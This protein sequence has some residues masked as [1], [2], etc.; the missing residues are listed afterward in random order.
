MTLKLTPAYESVCTLSQFVKALTVQSS[1]KDI[2]ERTIKDF[3]ATENYMTV[4]S[5]RRALHLGLTALHL[6][7]G[8]VIFPA[9]TPDIVP[10]TLQAHGL[11]P[12][13]ADVYA[14]DYTID[15]ES[16]KERISTHTKAVVPVHTFG[17]P[18][19]MHALTD[20]CKDHNIYLIENAAPSFG[21]QYKSIPVGRYGDFGIFSFRLGK[22][23]V[24]GAGGGLTGSDEVFDQIHTTPSQAGNSLAFGGWALSWAVLSNPFLY[25]ILGHTLKNRVVRHQYD[26]FKKDLHDTKDIP[27]L[28]YAVGIQKFES[29]KRKRRIALEYID[30]LKKV[31]GVH[32]PVEKK[33]RYSVYSMFSVRVESQLKRDEIAQKMIHAHIEPGIPA[34]GYP[35][36]EDLYPSRFDIPIS[37][38]LSRTSIALPVN[39]R[40]PEDTLIDI[41]T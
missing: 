27:A 34:H 35:V 7:K 36:S 10:L 25:Y 9:F 15:I 1:A 40:I 16:V 24:M 33:D 32:V 18:S 4:S 20:I 37:D 17:Y 8:H 6:T 30:I 5:G 2:F 41:F 13:P 14:D 21:A 3:L 19:D 38:M 26:T 31:D 28:A 12:V 22:S 11:T 29:F 23:L 39:T